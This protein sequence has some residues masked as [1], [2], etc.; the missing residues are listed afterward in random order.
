[1]IAPLWMPHPGYPLLGSV[2]Y[3]VV[4]GRC[5]LVGSYSN[6]GDHHDGPDDDGIED[7]MGLPQTREVVRWWVGASGGCGRALARG[8][9]PDVDTAMAAVEAAADALGLLGLDACGS[10]EW[11]AP[12]RES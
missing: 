2:C 12:G 6:D 11:D 7:V 5:L 4:G 8:Y 1:V 9:A 10:A 3:R